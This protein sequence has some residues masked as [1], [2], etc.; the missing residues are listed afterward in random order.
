MVNAHEKSA[1]RSALAHC[2]SEFKHV[3]HY[4]D[5]QRN[6]VVAKILPGEFYMT[7][8]E[9]LI[10][11]TLGSCISAC[12]WDEQAQVGGM[13]HFMLPATDKN[14]DEVDW[15]QR[16]LASDATRYGNFAMEHLINMLL[17]QGGLRRNLKAKV[18]GG[19]KVL[20]KMSDIGERNTAF[21][22]DYLK[23]E[24][25]EVI[26]HDVG[27]IY[28]RKVMFDPLTGRAFVK[29]LDNLHN[30]TIAQ[31]ESDYRTRIDHEVVEGDVE[32]F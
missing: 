18:F 6:T 26:N 4:W 19:G 30:D 31:R 2:A 5:K 13:N 9:V 21:V 7:S 12:I 29:R 28:P 22:F 3:N 11:T 24:R 27:S 14:A 32:L 15:G 23:T 10:S 20:K 17:K 25:I 8:D 16:G 1:L